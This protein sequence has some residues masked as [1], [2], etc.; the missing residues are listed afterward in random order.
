MRYKRW[1]TPCL[2]PRSHWNAP[3]PLKSRG[4]YILRWRSMGL[5]SRS[6]SRQSTRPILTATLEHVR[7]KY[8]PPSSRTAPS[9]LESL[10]KSA[11]HLAAIL[12]RGALK[13][14]SPSPG[15]RISA[16]P[17]SLSPPST[18]EY[19]PS[20]TASFLSR[21]STYRLATYA[22]KPSKIDAVAAAKC[23]WVNDGRDRL[24]CGVCKISWIV[25]STQGMKTEA[26]R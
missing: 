23:G 14:Q 2:Y 22:N 6:P 20:S 8:R 4:R 15:S 9:R 16:T 24:L 26:G 7:L 10:T 11:P 25:A 12:S 5:R 13:S 18:S 1:T 17:L 21:L 19:R 3:L